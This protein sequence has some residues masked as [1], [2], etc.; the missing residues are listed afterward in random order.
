MYGTVARIRM[1]PGTEAQLR[2]IEAESAS[3]IPGFVFQHTFRM[4]EDPNEYYMVVAFTDK[5]TYV[6]NAESP[7]QHQRYLRY[8]ALLEEEPDWHDGE[9]AFSIPEQ[10]T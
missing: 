9:I 7:E 2:E 3:E 6:R 5:K 4:D 10:T 8:R 1:K